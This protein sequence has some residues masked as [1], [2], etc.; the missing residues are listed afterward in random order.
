MSLQGLPVFIEVFWKSGVALGAALCVTRL[1]RKRSAD[2]RR[3]VLSSAIVAIF[4][5]VLALPLLPRWT[6]SMPDWPQ[7]QRPAP[8]PAFNRNAKS[9]IADGATQLLAPL[10]GTARPEAVSGKPP[11]AI[12]LIWFL[13]T[14]L[15]LIRFVRGLRGLHRLRVAS[16]PVSDAELLADLDAA[17]ASLGGARVRRGRV[18]LMHNDSIAAPLTWG[19]LWGMSRP[20]IL[21]PAGFAQLRPESR[22]AILCHESAHIQA[23]D[24]FFRVLAEIARCLIWF[25][26]LMWIASRQLREEQELACDDRVL[27]AGRKPSVYA[28]LLLDWG[29]PPATDFSVAAGMV[30]RSSLRRRIYALLDRDLRRNQVA[31]AGTLATWFL[32]LATALP[33]AA[34]RLAPAITEQPMALQPKP[35]PPMLLPWP[36]PRIQLVQALP[37]PAP[38]PPPHA[39]ATIV[40][41]VPAPL[42]LFSSD[43]WLVMVDVI[44]REPSGKAVEGL[45]A[46]DFVVTEDGK[47]Q[48]I[49]FFEFQNVNDLSPGI[50]NY[51]VLGYYAVP[52]ADGLYRRIAM[53]LKG[54]PPARLE[55]RAGHYADKSFS[56]DS[57]N[58]I[59]AHFTVADAADGVA[60]TNFAATT[61]P[62][63]VIFK[64][65][66]EYSEQARKAK[67]SGTVALLV[68]VSP[69]GQV[70]GV[71][72]IRSLGMGLDEKA[73]EAI[74]HWKFRPGIKDGKPVATQLQVNLN[75]RLL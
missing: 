27:S 64:Q 50:S 75:F 28:R 44:V 18:A 36:R 68:D 20:V 39:A 32:G 45:D 22:H 65:D 26:P 21:V 67:Y 11:G 62:P 4:V 14:A 37:V 9:P 47:P 41:A 43:T 38:P 51:Y 8:P 58:N 59:R 52:K 54:N 61:R 49:K 30:H 46:S 7:F 34:I 70:T 5:A 2:L 57:D 72:V 31:A 23:H 53:A 6:A 25:Q 3:L 74:T 19:L 66:P 42:P 40:R 1:L 60:Q 17:L 63:A 16:Q 71:T 13:G 56:S 10:T 73:V 48:A 33:L 24:F 69:S 15:F 12:P 55:Y 29:V 35:P